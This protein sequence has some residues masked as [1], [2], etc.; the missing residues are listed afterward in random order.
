MSGNVKKNRR[1]N[2]NV[3]GNRGKKVA[4]FLGFFF[5]ERRK[6]Y[7]PNTRLGLST[8]CEKRGA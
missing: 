4:R 3:N 2:D 1:G 6:N 5:T 7:Y 8:I